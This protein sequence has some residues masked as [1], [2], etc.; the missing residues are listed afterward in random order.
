MNYSFFS[1]SS[2]S[3]INEEKYN[4]AYKIAKMMDISLV[5]NGDSGSSGDLLLNDIDLNLN[6]L[7]NAKAL[8]SSKKYGDILVVADSVDKFQ[9]ESVVRTI[10]DDEKLKQKIIDYLKK[11][12]LIYNENVK[13]VSIFDLIVDKYTPKRELKNFDVA[14]YLGALSNNNYKTNLTL[15]KI[16]KKSGA[17]LLHFE[18]R[19]SEIGYKLDYSNQVVA[20]KLV[21]SV[22]LDAVDSGANVIVTDS[23]IYKNIFKQNLNKIDKLY[24][25]RDIKN[26]KVLHSLELIALSL[27]ITNII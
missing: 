8:A 22:V 9:L 7:I 27:N 19:Y 11:I 24:E 15:E 18:K 21:E 17:N 4:L 1:N 12:D 2:Y 3:L 16:V 5:E 23:F 25:T 13:I 10:K 20:Q 6:Y 26:I 14:L